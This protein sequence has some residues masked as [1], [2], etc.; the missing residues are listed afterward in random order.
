MERVRETHFC[1]IFVRPML[2]TTTSK[3]RPAHDATSVPISPV[4]KIRK[5]KKLL[6]CDAI[7]QEE[8]D[9]FKKKTLGV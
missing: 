4:D 5:M 6:D 9:A 1:S 7:T 8:F 2:G 3:Q